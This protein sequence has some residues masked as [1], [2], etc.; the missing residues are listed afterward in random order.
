MTD[1]VT[2]EIVGWWFLTWCRHVEGNNL[3]G[4]VPASLFNRTGLKFTYDSGGL[5]TGVSSTAACT[6]LPDPPV[7][8]P[9]APPSISSRVP[10]IIGC[11]AGGLGVIILALI[12]CLLRF[13]PKVAASISSR[14]LL[15]ADSAAGMKVL[16]PLTNTDSCRQSCDMEVVVGSYF[17]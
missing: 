15:K 7:P 5:C 13:K 12:A 9:L 10:I 3:T 1:S 16:I 6:P 2:E 14:Q 17:V 4:Y 8:S 11:V